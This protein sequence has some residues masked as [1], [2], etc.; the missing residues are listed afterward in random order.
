MPYLY[1]IILCVTISIIYVKI[2]RRYTEILTTFGTL[3]NV[4]KSPAVAILNPLLFHVMT[5]NIN[6]I[7]LYYCY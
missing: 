2:V 6:I 3:G 5:R 1:F 4:P 7:I